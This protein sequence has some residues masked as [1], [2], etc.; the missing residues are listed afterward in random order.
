MVSIRRDA[1]GASAVILTPALQ[2]RNG[3]SDG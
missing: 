2:Q 3:P 1:S